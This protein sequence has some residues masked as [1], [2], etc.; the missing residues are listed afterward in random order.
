MYDGARKWNASKNMQLT[1][2]TST[3]VSTV[4]LVDPYKIVTCK[5]CPV[6]PIRNIIN[7]HT[8]LWDNEM[9]TLVL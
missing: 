3:S 9:P 6:Q 7:E 4:S 2:G 8:Q 5:P 1:T